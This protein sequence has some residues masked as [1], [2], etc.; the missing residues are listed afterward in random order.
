[1][2]K[3]GEEV[4]PSKTKNLLIERL[5]ACIIKRNKL[6]STPMHGIIIQLR[7]FKE[8]VHCV[9]LLCYVQCQDCKHFMT[10]SGNTDCDIYA[11]IRCSKCK[12]FELA[13]YHVKGRG[14]FQKLDEVA[15]IVD[16]CTKPGTT[17]AEAF[18]QWQKAFEKKPKATGCGGCKMQ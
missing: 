18:R 5:N 14:E 9:A 17:R 12:S 3:I 2:I 10:F 11:P 6:V 7:D 8:F 15:E 13:S 4:I 1:M 16:E